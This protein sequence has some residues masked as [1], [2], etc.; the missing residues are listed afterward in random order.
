MLGFEDSRSQAVVAVATSNSCAAIRLKEE[1]ALLGSGHTSA[2]VGNLTLL[3]E[4]IV[5]LSKTQ[6]LAGR[7]YIS[8]WVNIGPWM[9]YP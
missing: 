4:F 2:W 9:P 5:K 7:L 6:V 3:P 8:S 1:A